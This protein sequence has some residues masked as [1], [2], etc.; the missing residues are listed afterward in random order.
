MNGTPARS[1]LAASAALARRLD[2]RA[3]R[4]AALIGQ[5]ARTPPTFADL[6][7]WPRWP[8]LGEVERGRI[9]A[10][11]ALVAGRDRLAEEIDG[12]RLR[13]Y[14][15]IVGEDALERVLALAPGGD[16]RLAAPP[17]LGATG[18]MLA[19]QGLPRALAERLGRSA[20]DLPQGDAF[21]RAAERIAEETA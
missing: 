16:R 1:R 3:R 11:A 19:E 17:A 5:A 21:V 13:D 15:A 12:E 10:L 2:P 14:A 18:R 4:G 20:T 6:A 8:A 9:F 7:V